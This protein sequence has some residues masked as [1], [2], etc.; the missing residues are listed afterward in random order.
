MTLL[1]MGGRIVAGPIDAQED[2]SEA[3]PQLEDLLETQDL[4]EAAPQA[5]ALLA[6]VEASTGSDSL[7]TAAAI[8]LI[9]SRWKGKGVD[10]VEIRVLANRSVAIRE[11]HLGS[12]DLRVAESLKHLAMLYQWDDQFEPARAAFARA[13]AIEEEI[14]G[15]DHP[16]VARTLSD[17]A[18]LLWEIDDS[19]ESRALCERAVA[20]IHAALGPDDMAQADCLRILAGHLYRDA[21]YAGSRDLSRRRVEVLERHHGPEDPAVASALLSLSNRTVMM[22]EF[23]ETEALLRRALAINEKAGAGTEAVHFNLGALYIDLGDYAMAKQEYEIAIELMEE[24]YPP[25]HR[26]LAFARVNLGDV[27]NLLG[28][29]DEARPLLLSALEVYEEV[30]GPDDWHVADVLRQL[31]RVEQDSGG[32][33]EARGHF[34]RALTILESIPERRNVLAKTLRDLGSLLLDLGDPPEA[35]LSYER[36]LAVAREVYEPGN[37]YLVGYAT[38]LA[39]VEFLLGDTAAARALL[40][41]AIEIEAAQVGTDHPDYFR[42][43]LSLAALSLREGRRAE[44]L[45][46][47]SRVVEG[48][49]QFVRYTLAYLPERQALS[50]IEARDHPEM[51]LLDGL[52]GNGDDAR[53]WL[54]ALWLW[55]LNRRGVVLDELASRHR[56]ALAGESAEALAA[57][58]RLAAARRRLGG[59]WISGPGS[60]GPERYG[61]LLRDARTEKESAELALAKVSR[62]FRDD[63]RVV[64]ITPATIAPALPPKGAL[65]E[66]VRSEAGHPAAAGRKRYDIALILRPDGSSDYVALGPADRTDELVAGW[67]TE[68]EGSLERLRG[69]EDDLSALAAAGTALRRAIWDPIASRL[70]GAS[71]VYLVPEGPLHHVDLAALPVEDG[72]FLIE[73]GPAVRLVS[74]SRSLLDTAAGGATGRGILAVGAPDFKAPRTVRFASLGPLPGDDPFRGTSPRCALRGRSWAELP[75]SVIEVRQ[76]EALWKD[77]EPVVVLTRDRASEERFKREAPG[78]RVLHLATHGY[79]VRDQCE[80]LESETLRNPLLRSGLV[81][82]GANLSE[83]D[84][85]DGE[86][87][88]LTAEELAALDLR[89]V[90]LAVLSACDTGRGEVAI[91]EGVFGLRRALEIAGVDSIVMSL[92]PVPDRAAARFMDRFYEERLEGTGV[93]ESVRRA[94]LAALQELR[95][96]EGALHP[97]YWSGFVASGAAD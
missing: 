36:A 50:M 56:T 52:L 57:W 47:V 54:A 22:G 1:L 67:R 46:Q 24:K 32:Y 21:D 20:I 70:R 86:D 97:Y 92:W 96:R 8:D 94:G 23:E 83:A 30:Y 7:E 64:L 42:T 28:D 65:V 68:L 78:K 74:T 95:D 87:G 62:R 34:T 38:D 73:S 6:E 48:L 91:G 11:A 18:T 81:M 88:I 3:L 27:L 59:L 33:E 13:L 61:E 80:G 71:I 41:E 39:D 84:A 25:G 77:R 89:G 72:T 31:G 44:A 17:Y 60:L 29:Q 43:L 58:E 45:Q 76:I 49:D 55:T 40:E 93:H 63:Q 37:L 16:D 51:V 26:T 66:I 15:T 2:T 82:A 69:G 35:A 10:A 53:A 14:L 75:A 79:F 5:L 90:E 12:V 19:P 4:A 9:V 85:G